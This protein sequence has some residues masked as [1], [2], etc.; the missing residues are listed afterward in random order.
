VRS[1]RPRSGVSGL[2]SHLGYWLRFVSNHVSREFRRK[3]EAC[4]VQVSEWVVLREVYDVEA[5]S[6][7]AL[8]ERTGMTKGAVSK[9]LARLEDRGLVVR[10]VGEEDRRQLAVALTARGRALV[11]RLARLAD[12][13]DRECF[14]H[15]PRRVRDEVARAMRAVVR[16][17]GWTTVPVE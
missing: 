1:E 15:L 13:N 16:H 11:P 4:G 2:E 5:A 14:G 7:G 6:P 12:E 8:V 10:R 3:V 17:H 9:L